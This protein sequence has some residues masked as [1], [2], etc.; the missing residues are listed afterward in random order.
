[1]K[2]VTAIIRQDKLDAVQAALQMRQLSLF[3]QSEVFDDVGGLAATGMYRGTKFQ[4]RPPKLRIEIAVKDELVETAVEA[5]LHSAYT[6]ASAQIGEIKVIVTP[7]DACVLSVL[8]RESAQPD[9]TEEV[10]LAYR[11]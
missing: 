9:D 11:G 6:A 7:S 8:T 10:R 4:I 1:M 2:L 5:I 3:S